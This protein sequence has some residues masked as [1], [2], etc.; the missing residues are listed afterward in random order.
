MLS[1]ALRRRWRSLA[2]FPGGFDEAGAAAVWE[3]GNEAAREMLGEM[4]ALSLVEWNESAGRYRLHDLA[5]VFA[6]S[7]L[8]QDERSVGGRRHA[9]HY[10]R[11][12]AA[13][14]ALYLKGGV[15]IV[16]GLALFDRER[17]NIEA[18]Q[19]WA[20]TRIESDESAAILCLA[21]LD[22]VA[23]IINLRQHPR[24]RIQLLEAM[25]AVARRFNRRDAERRA[26]G[27]LG[28]AYQHLS[29]FSRAIE[30]YNQS[31]NI[32]R[33][34]GDRGGEG[35]ML[36]NLGVAYKALDQ[37]RDALELYEQALAVFR[38]IGD[39]RNEGTALGN[40]G[41]V[42]E[43]LGEPLLA[44]ERH[45][46]RLVIAR[47]VGDRGGEAAAF[48]NLGKAYYGLNKPSRAI[49]LFD[50]QLTI[51]REIGDPRLEAHGL[52]GKAT[53]IYDRGDSQQAIQC[54]ETALRIY[55]Q[56]EAPEADEVMARLSMWK[57]DP[58]HNGASRKS[59][60][61]FSL[62]EMLQMSWGFFKFL[63]K[64]SRKP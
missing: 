60:V 37:P 7:R 53:A 62:K 14:N 6:D 41:V 36:H 56:I 30:F 57:D 38:E 55:Q 18:G 34:T 16:R 5:R 63:Q 23:E 46:Q 26:L 1:E 9:E 2:V 61:G 25:L 24:T 20:A 59:Q 33:E 4:I 15:E 44:I 45:E 3:V 58:L 29:D 17:A 11:V 21:Y 43:D 54:M 31:L 42:Y 40:I 50:Q 10:Q 48:A 39:R 22:V 64:M 49:E 27:N 28:I 12:L 51:A 52:Y 13:V 32:A 35:R 8:S 47:E 19:A